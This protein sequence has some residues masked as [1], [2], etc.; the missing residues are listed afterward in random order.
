[1]LPV[2]EGVGAAG[3]RAL[4]VLEPERRRR[5]GASGA[6]GYRPEADDVKLGGTAWTVH[7]NC[8]C[9]Q[10]SVDAMDTQPHQVRDE[11]VCHKASASLWPRQRVPSQ[12]SLCRFHRRPCVCGESER[13]TIARESGGHTIRGRET[14]HSL[15]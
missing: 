5:Q 13:E 3:N 10:I 9:E 14:G 4:V 1:M 8:R 15:K 7:R 11:D 6:F 12:P 2:M